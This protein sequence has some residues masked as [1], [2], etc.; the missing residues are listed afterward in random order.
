MPGHEE[1]ALGAIALHQK[2]V[3]NDALLNHVA[4]PLLKNMIAQKEKELEAR[5]KLYRHNKPA[6]NVENK[7]V[8]IVDDGIATGASMRAA[9][10][11]LK[12]QHPTKIIIAIPVADKSICD[13]LLKSVD[14][15]VCLFQPDN[16]SAVGQWYE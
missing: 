3:F 9:L 1:F 11:T 6:P 16:L 10:S 12:D 15:V 5:N 2:P 14:D 8:I 13:D 7:M 4:A